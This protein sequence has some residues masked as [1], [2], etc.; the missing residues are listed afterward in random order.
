MPLVVDRGACLLA[1]FNPKDAGL[2]RG[3]ATETTDQRDSW[4]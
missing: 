1:V 3:E 4:G 2:S